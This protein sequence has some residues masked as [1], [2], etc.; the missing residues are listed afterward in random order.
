MEKWLDFH[1][2]LEPLRSAIDQR[3]L[4]AQAV[5]RAKWNAEAPIEDLPREAQVIQSAVSQGAALGL[6][7]DWVEAVWRAQIE[8]SKTVQRELYAT[9]Q[10]QKAGRFETRPISPTPSAR[11]WTGSRRSFCMRWR[12]T[13]TCCA[14]RNGKPRSHARWRRWKPMR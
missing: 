2:E 5:A 14:I 6:P 12:R 7:A 4:L 11:S 13:A 8:A 10:A 9:W 3:L 1:W